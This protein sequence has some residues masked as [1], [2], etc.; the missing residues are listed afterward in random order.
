LEGD[1]RTL[2]NGFIRAHPRNARGNSSAM[3]SNLWRTPGLSCAALERGQGA[4]ANRVLAAGSS[5]QID[6][7]PNRVRNVHSACS[8]LLF[9]LAAAALSLRNG[10]E[11]GHTSA[12]KCTSVPVSAS[13]FSP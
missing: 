5:T 4:Q 3:S 12:R 1:Q 7:C 2:A 8:L 6:V 11:R 10:R 13:S 9:R